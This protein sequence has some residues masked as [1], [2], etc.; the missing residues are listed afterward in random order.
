M[1]WLVRSVL[2]SLPTIVRT[3]RSPSPICSAM[4]RKLPPAYRYDRGRVREQCVNLAALFSTVQKYLARLSGLRVEPNAGRKRL[5]GH[6]K[7][8]DVRRAAIR[9]SF[10]GAHGVT[11]H[12]YILPFKKMAQFLHFIG[13]GPGT[14]R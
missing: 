13:D 5:P 10:P 11:P 8:L 12:F 4:A 6:L 14:V 1:R 9:E 3:V 7:G 2:A